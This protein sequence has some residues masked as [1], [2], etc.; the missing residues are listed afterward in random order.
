V[1]PDIR[2][3]FDQNQKVPINHDVFLVVGFVF[4]CRAGI[5]LNTTGEVP[6]GIRK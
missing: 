3:L 6:Q 4:V 2:S 5:H 1:F